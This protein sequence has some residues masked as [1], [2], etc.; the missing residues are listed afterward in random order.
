MIEDYHEISIRNISSPTRAH[1]AFTNSLENLHQRKKNEKTRANG[2]PIQLYVETL[3]VAD[4]SVYETVSQLTGY[5]DQDF[6]FQYMRIYLSHMVNG[7]NMAYESSL[8]DDPDLRISLK[9]A[10]FY[11]LTVLLNE[12]LRFKN[13]D[14][15]LVFCL[16]ESVD[17]SDPDKVGFESS[18]GKKYVKASQSL[19]FFSNFMQNQ[20]FSIN[21]DHAIGLLK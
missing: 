9:L 10:N 7:A 1:D 4:Q 20:R 8:R 15:W 17:W 19:E 3:L 16:K 11:F 18:D 2:K 12:F 21:Y 14:L 13:T 6:V 5:T